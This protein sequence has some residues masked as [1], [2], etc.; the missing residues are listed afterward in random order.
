MNPTRKAYSVFIEELCGVSKPDEAFKLLKEMYSKMVVDDSL[1]CLVAS[2]FNKNGELEM[3]NQV[4]NM[5]RTP[6]VKNPE[7]P[8]GAFRSDIDF[9]QIPTPITSPCV[10]VPQTKVCRDKD[11]QEVCRILSSTYSWSLMQKLLEK[12]EIHFTPCLVEEVLYRC[13]RHGH[14]TLCFFSWVSQQPGYRHTTEMYNMAIKIS[15]SGKDFKHM[16]SLF[17]EM[18]SRG[19]SPTLNTWNIMITQYG[20]AGLTDFMLK[21]FKQMKQEAFKPNRSTYKF[22]IV[23]LCGKES[24]KADEAIKI[25][26][27]MICEGHVPDN[28]VIDAYLSCLCE[29]G[30][31]SE[32][33]RCVEIL[34][35]RGLAPQ[36]S[37]TLLVKSLCRTRRLEEAM[38][39]VDDMVHLGCVVDKYIYGSIVYGLL[40]EGCLDEALAK[41]ESMRTHGISPTTHIY[42]S[43]M[44]YYLKEKQLMKA[45]QIFKKMKEDG[46]DP[47][48]ITYS[49][50]IVD[51]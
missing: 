31:L 5:C 20:R 49:A 26:Q 30:K 19:C 3:A 11:L 8:N 24:R 36:K 6:K 15:G 7:M 33:K 51:T 46:C 2:S 44:I 27:E 47:S 34:C 17:L 35:E 23:F 21:K 32:A 28:E 13:Q 18:G 39:L 38:A 40:K 22:V 16:T 48:I 10:D 12:R 29:V 37:Y 43:L 14:A 1:L 25:F 45:M 50:L 41:V 9:N 42:T 4:E